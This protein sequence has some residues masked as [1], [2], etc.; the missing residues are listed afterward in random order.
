MTKKKNELL[1]EK[2][3]LQYKIEE[4]QFECPDLAGQ[5]VFENPTDPTVYKKQLDV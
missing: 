1:K 5:I 4:V 2:I 3:V